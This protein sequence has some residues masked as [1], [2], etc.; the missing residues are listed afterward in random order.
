MRHPETNEPLSQEQA[1]HA[2]SQVETGNTPYPFQVHFDSMTPLTY[3]LD[4]P[5]TNKTTH[6]CV[7]LIVKKK[8]SANV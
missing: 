8:E 3:F 2:W 6:D 7:N 5:N 1:F 4:L